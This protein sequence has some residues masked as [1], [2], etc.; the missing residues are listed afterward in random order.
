MKWLSLDERLELSRRAVKRAGK[1]PVVAT[2]N[3]SLNT[4]DHLEEVKCMADTGVAAVVLVP[5][6]GL[7][8]NTQAIGD[9]YATLSDATPCPTLIYEW[10]AVDSYLLPSDVYGQLANH[11]NIWGIKDTTCTLEGITAKIH[12]APDSVVYQANHPY[13]LDAIRNGARGIMAIST[14]A[15]ADWVLRFWHEAIAG[16]EHAEKLLVELITLDSLLIH[17]MSYPPTAKVMAQLRGMDMGLTCR[18]PVALRDETV[19]AI[20]LWYHH[21]VAGMQ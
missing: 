14:A 15:N 16:G 13:M 12:A 11:H 9:Y 2:G 1:I 17:N 10:P 6:H 7:G 4:Q 19:K 21:Q 20:T 8:V 18:N 5:T 3:V